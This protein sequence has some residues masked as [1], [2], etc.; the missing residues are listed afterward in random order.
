V[1]LNP[2][3]KSTKKLQAWTEKCFTIR[4]NEN[5]KKEPA[6]KMENH[7]YLP[8]NKRVTLSDIK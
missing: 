2:S 8:Q 3:R 6:R 4:I 1:E 5:S 7:I